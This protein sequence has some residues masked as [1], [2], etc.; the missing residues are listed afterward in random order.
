MSYMSGLKMRELLC[1][2]LTRIRNVVRFSNSTRIKDES[3]AEHSYFAAYYSLILGRMLESV[4]AI[5]IDYGLLLTRALLHDLDE[6][7]SG[8]F[9]RHFKYVD[10]ELHKKLD[11]ASGKLMQKEA[12]TGI[13]TGKFICDNEFKI[14]DDLYQHWKCAKS[15]DV[16]GDIVAFAD[17]LSVLSYVMNEIDCG[18]KRLITQLDDMYEYAESF[19]KRT[20]FRQQQ[21]ASEWL[22]Q[23]MVLLNEYLGGRDER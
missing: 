18:N 16:E 7:I 11:E 14:T 17:F 20:L 15:S 1:G 2:N 9:V 21:E 23:V 8:D 6:A 4:T 12:F 5:E 19:R 3:V 10:P 13:F 22:N